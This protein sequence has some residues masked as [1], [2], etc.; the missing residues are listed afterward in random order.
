MEFPPFALSPWSSPVRLVALEP[1]RSSC[2]LE[3]PPFV[4][5]EFPP[6]VLRLSKYERGERAEKSTAKPVIQALSRKLKTPGTQQGSSVSEQNMGKTALIPRKSAAPDPYHAFALREI[7]GPVL[8]E[9]EGP[10]LREIEGRTGG[11]ERLPP[12]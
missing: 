7:E 9:I 8:R 3:F 10:V 12:C 2:R 6:F 5:M 4:D 1:P 11:P